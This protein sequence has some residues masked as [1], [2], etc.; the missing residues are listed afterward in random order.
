MKLLA[1]QIMVRHF[2]LN[3]IVETTKIAVNWKSGWVK[4]LFLFYHWTPLV[5]GGKNVRQIV[6]YF[7]SDDEQPKQLTIP[8][9]AA[10][11]MLDQF[12]ESIEF[13]LDFEHPNDCKI[14]EKDLAIGSE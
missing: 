1:Y 8:N 13:I 7:S 3:C 4:I 9:C 2:H 14:D 5:F 10:P 6:F 12:V 11:C